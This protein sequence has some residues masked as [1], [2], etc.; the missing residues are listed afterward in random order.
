MKMAFLASRSG[1]PPP[2][3]VFTS[4]A[5]TSVQNPAPI[6]AQL[7]AATALQCIL[8]DHPDDPGRRNTKVVTQRNNDWEAKS[9]KKFD[10]FFAK[11]LSKG[12]KTKKKTTKKWWLQYLT[13]SVYPVLYCSILWTIVLPDKNRGIS[14]CT[15]DQNDLWTEV[16]NYERRTVRV[17][18]V[19]RQTCI[20][21]G[22]RSQNKLYLQ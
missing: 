5:L 8:E 21:K 10:F 9:I 6:R 22:R 7:Y 12:W 19:R 3:A 20:W 1:T 18:P 14:N 17:W 11:L 13:A 4:V 15:G 2:H 16:K